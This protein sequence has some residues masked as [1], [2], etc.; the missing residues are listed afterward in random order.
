MV[1]DSSASRHSTSKQ[2]P[3]RWA[4]LLTLIGVCV[5]FVGVSRLVPAG[6]PPW[7]TLGLAILAIL[8]TTLVLYG[9]EMLSKVLA[10][11]AWLGRGGGQR[12]DPGA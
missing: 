7:Q 3:S 11:C 12:E 8:A 2:P 1:V 6:T 5:L 10:A 4:A 9:P